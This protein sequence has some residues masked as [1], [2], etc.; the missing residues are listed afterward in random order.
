MINIL[1]E[2]KYMIALNKPSGLLTHP[3]NECRQIKESLLFKVRD[4]LQGLYV[5]PVNRLDRAVS[6]IVL[7]AKKKEV[8]TRMQNNWN[9]QE[10]K[11]TYIA[12]CKGELIEDGL[13]NFELSNNKKVKQKAITKYRIIKTYEDLSHLYINIETGRRHQIR[14]HFS[15]RMHA[16]AGDR[17]YGK[18]KWNDFYLD[19]FM[20]KRI[21]LHSS[22]LEF[23]HPYNEEIIKIECPLP[24]DLN[25]SLELIENYYGK[26][27]QDKEN[28]KS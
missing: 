19:N 9:T 15:R 2:D 1:Y 13:F 14:R 23:K 24:D 4:H 20:L 6:G 27:I 5:Y 8:V 22:C 21:F 3:S 16:L 17:K 28:A 18:K 12:L 26:K 7:F 10:T 25:H 11:K